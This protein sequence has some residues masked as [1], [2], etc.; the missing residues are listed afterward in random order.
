MVKHTF[1]VNWFSNNEM[2]YNVG[3]MKY[4]YTFYFYQN[5][6]LFTQSKLRHLQRREV[7]INYGLETL[8]KTSINDIPQENL[9]C[10]I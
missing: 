3:K 6:Y 5:F 4:I 8:S 2:F 9:K 7:Y 10:S 1:N